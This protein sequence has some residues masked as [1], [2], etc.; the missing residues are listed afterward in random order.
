[1]I[2]LTR[3]LVNSKRLQVGLV[4]SWKRADL[5][6]EL[7]GELSYFEQRKMLWPRV[8]DCYWQSLTMPAVAQR[9]EADVIV[10]VDPIGATTG[11]RSR[12]FV[13]HDLY[14]KTLRNQY[15]WKER[16]CSDHIFRKMLRCNDA[17]VCVSDSTLYDLQRHYP[18]AKEKSFRVYSGSPSSSV[19]KKQAFSEGTHLL[20]VSNVTANKNIGCFYEALDML[21]QR[22]REIKTIVVGNDPSGLEVQA[23]KRLRYA[24][25]PIRLANISKEFLS[26]LYGTCLCLVNT[27]HGE[28]FGFPVLEA[29]VH[30]APV[31]CPHESA[32]AEIGGA[33]AVMTFQSGSAKDLADQVMEL[34]SNRGLQEE[35]S[36]EGL[37]NSKRFSWDRTARSLE[38]AIFKICGESE[39]RQS[40]RVLSS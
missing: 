2:N 21:A 17:V 22:D 27:S 25:P 29:Q 4:T 18:E 19:A 6:Q 39:P 7:V 24:T 1:M 26:K 35:L 28:G 8:I 31:V 9:A 30:G 5:P 32:T 34:Q 11:A 23:R 33:Q 37:R 3:S 38:E 36:R 10:N 14:F 13:A 15:S 12:I 16:V 20:W 40:E